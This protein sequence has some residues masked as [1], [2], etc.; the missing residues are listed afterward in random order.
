VEVSRYTGEADYS[1]LVLKTFE[2]FQQGAPRDYRVDYRM[3]PGMNHVAA[4]VLELV[5]L[6]F[7]EEFAA[8]DSYCGRHAAFLDE[9][10]RPTPSSSSISPTST[11]SG[12]SGRPG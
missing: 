9:G 2:R 6:L 8:L 4:Q 11:T 7:G 12:R 3:W 10:G 1:A 5:A